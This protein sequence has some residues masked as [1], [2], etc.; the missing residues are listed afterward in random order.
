MRRALLALAL[1]AGLAALA[2]T[3]RADTFAIAP[4]APVGLPSA[5]TPNLPGSIALPVPLSQPPAVPAQL[6]YADLDALWRRAGAA[7]GIP[8]QLLAAINKV[9]SNF[10]RNMGPSSAGAIGWMQFMPSTWTRWGLD[11]SG[12]GVADPWNPDDAV[13]SAARYL[14]AAGGRLDLARAVFAYNHAQWYVDEVL[15]LARLFGSAG[16]QETF[17]LDRLQLGLHEASQDVVA[18][19]RL[20]VDARRRERAAARVE[21]RLRGRVASARL[22]SDRLAAEQRAAL[23][24]VRRRALTARVAELRARLA[25]T[26]QR[27]ETLRESARTASFAPGA[28]TVLAAPSYGESGRHVFPV[29]GGAGVVFV[30]HHHHDYPAADIAAPA[31]SPVYALADA[32]V[33]RAWHEPGGRCGI[34]TTI[35]T[36]DGLEWTYCHLAVLEP[37]VEAG[38]V[39]SAG[40]SV[41]FVG[42]TGHATGPHLHLQLQPPTRYPQDEPW[43]E[44]FAG[45][46]FTWE[47][48]A[49]TRELDAAPVAPRAVFAVV[50]EASAPPPG[51]VVE[52]TR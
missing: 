44:S 22:L 34:G 21:A 40:A 48:G 15:S 52:F 31:G 41:G 26:Q 47:D 51:D 4:P 12:D 23:A 27:L 18:L 8:W 29:G 46:A 7:Y 19:G 39:L 28:A 37:G 13:Y 11:A 35:R 5:E 38:A 33:E 42:S 30:S 16:P 3:A 43:F 50:P 25:A 45:S 1:G 6:S 17:R 9:E 36:A 2:G 32:V 10:G 20:V 14:A 49:P 24:S